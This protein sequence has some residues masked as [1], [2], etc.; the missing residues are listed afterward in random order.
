MITRRKEDTVKYLLSHTEKEKAK[1]AQ[2]GTVGKCKGWIQTL[3]I[4]GVMAAVIGPVLYANYKE[5]M[6]VEV[7]TEETTAKARN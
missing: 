7:D 5:V 2:I 1:I 4:Y 3:I 6:G